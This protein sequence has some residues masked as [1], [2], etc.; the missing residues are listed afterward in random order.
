MSLKYEDFENI[1][2]QAENLLKEA[3]ASRVANEAVK[4]MAEREM[5]KLPKPKPKA[6]AAVK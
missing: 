3:E 4:A 6:N 2:R 5:K 1:K